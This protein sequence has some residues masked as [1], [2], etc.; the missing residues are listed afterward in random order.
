MAH[1]LRLYKKQRLC[2]P[3]AIEALFARS[4]EC[5]GAL[6]YP[7]RAVW[8]PNPS[9]RSDSPLAFVIMVP[10]RRLRH[11]VDRV[12]MRRRI[13]EAYRLHHAAYALPEGM[14]RT[15]VAFV[16]VGSRTE[17]YEAVERA[18]HK[19]LARITAAPS[20]VAPQPEQP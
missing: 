17:P 7:L 11:A 2:S 15:D 4:P 14:E 18:M 3:T 9:R 19:L 6:A 8:R 12:L 1:P 16:Y 10:K 5:A 20:P 13:R